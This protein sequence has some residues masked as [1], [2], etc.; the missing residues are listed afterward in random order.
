MELRQLRYFKAIADARSFVRAAGHLCVAQPALSRSMARL[1]DEIGQ[2]LFVRHATGVS[3]TEAG[4]HLYDHVT[5][6]LR[7]VQVLQDSMAAEDLAPHGVV[8]FGAPASFNSIVTA[9]VVAAFMKKF[10]KSTVNVVQDTSVNLRDA[11]SSDHLDVAIISTLTASSGLRYSPLFTEG[12]CLVE[13]ADSTVCTGDKIDVADL[14]GLPLILCGYPHTT[15]LYL[16]DVFAKL[17]IKPWFR[18]EANTASLVIDLVH[19][20]AGAGVVPSCALT[21]RTECDLRIRPINGL[22]LSWAIA[23]S[24]K[25]V[26]SVSVTELSAMIIHHVWDLISHHEWQ[27]ARFDGVVPT[28]TVTGSGQAVTRNWSEIIGTL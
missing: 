25:R 28:N 8:A 10:P 5:G 4:I 12:M 27:T 14:A 7:R 18:C 23:T 3:L 15:R 17:D 9:P 19:K 1:E 13:K 16:E 21:F 24:N 11:L 2:T 20:G 26:G 22:K 6:V